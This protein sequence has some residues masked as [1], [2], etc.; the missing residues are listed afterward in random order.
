MIYYYSFVIAELDLVFAN[1]FY[2]LFEPTY[3][4]GRV[5]TTYRTVE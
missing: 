1:A 2:G 4:M 5:L 3:Q